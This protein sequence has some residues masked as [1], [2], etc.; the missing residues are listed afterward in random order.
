MYLEIFRKFFFRFYINLSK[1]EILEVKTFGSK[2]SIKKSI[3]L[4]IYRLKLKKDAKIKEMIFFGVRM[5]V[6]KIKILSL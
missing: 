1:F 5:C 3:D 6:C 4:I 2:V